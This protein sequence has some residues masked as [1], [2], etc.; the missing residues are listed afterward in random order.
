MEYQL[1]RS[2]RKTISAEVRE[3]GIIVRAPLRTTR[4][5]A[6]AFLQKH[7]VWIERQLLKREE[8]R[9]AA[10]ALGKLTGAQL[11]DLYAQAREY[12]PARARHYA[13]L[14]GVDCGRVTI[15]CQHTRWGSCSTKGN[16]N[17][18]CLLMLAPP[19]V[20]D[21][22]IVHEVCHLQEMNHSPRFYALVLSLC[23]DYRTRD[24]WLKENGRLLLARLP[25]MTADR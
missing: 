3:S 24:G 18:N 11:S 15:R 6:D 13:G 20:I 7:K 5:E 4:R 1:I 12:I 19:E 16:L 2:R 23:P 25:D 22:V 8:R 21:A 14:L 10:E 17:F 9:A